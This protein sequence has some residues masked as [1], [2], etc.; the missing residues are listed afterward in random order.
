VPGQLT[1]AQ[2]FTKDAKFSRTDARQIAITE[3]VVENLIIGMCLPIYMV[4][5]REFKS[6]HKMFE[7]K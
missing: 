4:E 5:R 6:H 7:P 2:A 3:S 1:L